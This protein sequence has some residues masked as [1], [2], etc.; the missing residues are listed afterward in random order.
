MGLLPLKSD[1]KDENK[2]G[3]GYVA[4]PK[5]QSLKELKERRRE[6]RMNYEKSAN[7]KTIEGGY[8]SK[9]KRMLNV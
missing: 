6:E 2:V 3:T 7:L 1:P 4:M 8:E 9:Y 5:V